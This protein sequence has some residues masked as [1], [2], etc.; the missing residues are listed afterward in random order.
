MLGNRRDRQD[1]YD[2]QLF[3]STISK[4]AMKKEETSLETPKQD[5]YPC[6]SQD[7]RDKAS[8][9]EQLTGLSKTLERRTSGGQIADNPDSK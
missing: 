9:R 2:Q 8:D 1:I 4:E 7:D 5:T 6:N 3:H